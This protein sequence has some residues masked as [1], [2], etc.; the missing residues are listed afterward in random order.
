MTTTVP[1]VYTVGMVTLL[2]VP[3]P[4]TQYSVTV[5]A[6]NSAGASEAVSPILAQGATIVENNK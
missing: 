1:V 4:T 2:R 6:V 3:L 5:Q